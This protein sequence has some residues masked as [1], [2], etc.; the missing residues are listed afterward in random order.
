MTSCTNTVLYMQYM[1][2]CSTDMFTLY[3]WIGVQRFILIS[4]SSEIWAFMYSI[5]YYAGVYTVCTSNALSHLVKSSKQHCYLEMYRLV[6][7]SNIEKWSTCYTAIDMCTYCRYV[8]KL[9][10][11]NNLLSII[12]IS[13]LIIQQNSL[14]H[15]GR[16]H[17]WYFISL[18]FYLK[19]TASLSEKV[20]PFEWK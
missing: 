13:W 11:T 19:V 6:Q 9:N 18:N 20:P 14:L 4:V 10:K 7:S 12:K 15:V 16:V 3:S 1:F 8:L 17:H 5:L 2:I